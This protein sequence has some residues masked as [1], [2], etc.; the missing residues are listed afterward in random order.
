MVLQK[1]TIPPQVGI[2]HKLGHYSCLKKGQI[3]VPGNP[4]AFSGPI[5][6][7]GRRRI[8]VNNFDAA[9]RHLFAELLGNHHC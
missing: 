1:G 6:G 9:V 2:P 5:V 7:Q 3:L 4:I 8:L